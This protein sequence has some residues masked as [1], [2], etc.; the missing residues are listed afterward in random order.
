MLYGRAS[1]FGSLR[2]GGHATTSSRTLIAF[3]P[4]FCCCCGN[5]SRP[6][7]FTHAPRRLSET[8]HEKTY[9]VFRG[10]PRLSS[11]YAIAQ[12]VTSAPPRRP[13]RRRG[14]RRQEV[15]SRRN[16]RT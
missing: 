11:V 15:R 7:H 5:A 16:G 1:G 9:G 6:P 8:V 2:L 14:S 10:R 13:S 12:S 3:A 4:H